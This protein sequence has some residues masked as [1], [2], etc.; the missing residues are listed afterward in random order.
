MHICESEESKANALR[1]QIQ[2]SFPSSY[3]SW[4]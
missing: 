2:N 4:G 3:Y 1:T